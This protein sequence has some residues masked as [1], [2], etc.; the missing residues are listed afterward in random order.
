[1][2]LYG[3]IS[4][5]TTSRE[6]FQEPTAHNFDTGSRDLKLRNVG[7]TPL[8]LGFCTNCGAGNL[9]LGSPLGTPFRRLL[10]AVGEFF[11]PGKRRLK[12]GGSQD[13]LP[14]K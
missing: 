4:L 8:T 3:H 7:P 5:E 12:A 1:M 2:S 6:K 11:V 14:R 10:E 9:A 13:W